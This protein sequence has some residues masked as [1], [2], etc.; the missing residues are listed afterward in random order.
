MNLFVL[1]LSCCLWAF[2]VSGQESMDLSS[3]ESLSFQDQ[4][5]ILAQK[6]QKHIVGVEKQLQ[7]LD[8]LL[9][10]YYKDYNYTEED[11]FEYVSNPINTYMLIKRTALEWPMAKKV[12][13]DEAM[14][15]EFEEIEYLANFLHKKA[16]EEED[17][18][19]KTEL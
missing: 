7:T 4:E 13:F 5:Q 3:L 6:I 18:S 16:K 8:K 9:D 11:A 10:T 2:G 14:D 17:P 15:K 1:M 19:I 12:V